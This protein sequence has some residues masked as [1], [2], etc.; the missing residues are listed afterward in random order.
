M[1]AYEEAMSGETNPPAEIGVGRTAPGT[2]DALIVRFY[3]ST[4]FASWSPATQR[5][6]RNILE[7]FRAATMPGAR[8][9]NG[10]CRVAH[11]QAKH[12]DQMIAAKA[13]TPSAA[14]ALRKV[15]RV[16]MRFAV[17]ER[18]RRDDPTEGVG[19]L[20]RSSK[21]PGHATWGEDHIAAFEAHHAVGSRPRLALALLL[22]TAQR[23]G[24]V[25]RM[26]RQHLKGA[27][28]KVRQEKTGAELEIPLHPEL[29]A[30]INAT[31]RGNLTFL[32]TEFGK[33]FTAAG[34]G[35]IFREW[36]NDAGIPAGYTAHGLRKAACRRLAEAG[37]S[38]KQIQ[39]ISGHVTL[40]EVQRYTVAADQKSLAQS[41]MRQ[42]Y[43][44][45]K[46]ANPKAGLPKKGKKR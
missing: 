1:S 31:P 23:R 39:A 6:R 46:L 8:L 7:R 32:M 10:R 37:C 18:L 42:T 16:L 38:A 20:P 25:V 43:G 24:D 29:R 33:P 3:S 45:Q 26:G 21:R 5:A 28:I 14:A 11:L 22:Y 30:I 4:V 35:N 15:L 34:F 2:F 44:E 36:C 41:A 9:N 19:M 27:A 40:S 17:S 13:A 12:V